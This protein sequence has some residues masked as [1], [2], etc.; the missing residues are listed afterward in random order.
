MGI[1]TTPPPLRLTF[2]QRLTWV[3]HLFKAVAYQYHR[4]LLPQLKR[5]VPRNGIIIDVGAHAGQFAKLFSRLVPRGTV[6]AFEP[7]AYALSILKLVVKWKGLSNVRILRLG[8]SDESGSQ[9]LHVPLKRHGTFG[10]GLAHLGAP[11]G[12]RKTH[13]QKIR[14]STLDLFVQEHMLHRLDF[15]KA[16]IEGW[17]VNMLKGGLRSIRELRPSLMLEI[18]EVALKRANAS[19]QQIFDLILPLGYSVFRTDEHLDYKMQKVSGFDGTA[20]YL[21]VPQEKAERVQLG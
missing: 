1:D 17:E 3:A 14:L 19:P 20:D 6:Y 8:L 11:T 5:I 2:R 7:G 12:E 13:A 4:P 18:N 10:F 9:T 21:F 15:V 16:D